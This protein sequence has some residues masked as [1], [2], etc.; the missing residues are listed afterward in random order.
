MKLALVES[1]IDFVCNGLGAELSFKEAWTF[2]T[3]KGKM[4]NSGSK[5][6]NESTDEKAA[7]TSGRNGA[8]RKIL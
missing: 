2:A 3:L 8:S 7:K 5:H 6:Y 4:H 1:R